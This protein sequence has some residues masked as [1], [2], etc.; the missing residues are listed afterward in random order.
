[1]A[2]TWSSKSWIH[3]EC[4]E[5]EKWHAIL[6]RQNFGYE[7]EEKKKKEK[8]SISGERNGRRWSPY[9]FDRA[10]ASRER[11]GDRFWTNL[12][13]RVANLFYPAQQ[14]RDHLYFRRSPNK[15]CGLRFDTKIWL[16][17][18]MQPRDISKWKVYPPI[19]RVQNFV[20]QKRE[21][22]VI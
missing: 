13:H 10:T 20:K 8:N 12:F 5:W 1:M 14:I 2:R 22:L 11:R 9:L 15:N 19:S 18:I 17:R 21:E 6:S 16:P 3:K 4:L 7:R